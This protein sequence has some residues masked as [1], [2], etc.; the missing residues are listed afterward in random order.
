MERVNRLL[1]KLASMKEIICIDCNKRA[2]R[3]SSVCK[4]CLSCAEAKRYMKKKELE[5]SYCDQCFEAIKGNQR[6]CNVLCFEKF[7]QRNSTLSWLNNK[8]TFA[9]KKTALEKYNIQPTSNMRIAD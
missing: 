9:Y 3:K 7:K 6:F 1:E 4:R 8:K 2:F 5:I